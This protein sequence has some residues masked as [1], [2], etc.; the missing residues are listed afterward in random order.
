MR[1]SGFQTLR[2][3]T[4]RRVSDSVLIMSV[5]VTLLRRLRFS[6]GVVWSISHKTRSWR[7]CVRCCCWLK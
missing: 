3:S 1:E 4:L 2:A 6:F 5:G 7:V